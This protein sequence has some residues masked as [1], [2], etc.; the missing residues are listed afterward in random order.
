MG[1][2]AS[3]RMVYMDRQSTD[4]YILKVDVTGFA[5]GTDVMI[6][7]GKQKGPEGPSRFGVWWSGH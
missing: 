1:V 6:Q 7:K 5:G 3:R 4:G 2:A